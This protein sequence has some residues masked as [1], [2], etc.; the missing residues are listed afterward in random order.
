M[1]FD[2]SMSVPKTRRCFEVKGFHCGSE[3]DAGVTAGSSII[4][5]VF[6]RVGALM[7]GSRTRDEPMHA[8]EASRIVVDR[9]GRSQG[10]RSDSFRQ[11][12]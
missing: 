7:E 3:A 4:E 10:V 1:V 9:R 5:A 2:F 8:D 6:V 12:L 11:W